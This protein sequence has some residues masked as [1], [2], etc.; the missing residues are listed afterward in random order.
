MK[1]W[2]H[3]TN[4][5]HRSKEQQ[6]VAVPNKGVGQQG[7]LVVNLDNNSGY[8]VNIVDNVIIYCSCPHSHYRDVPCKH[9]AEIMKQV[10]NLELADKFLEEKE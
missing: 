1:V 4:S 10:P 8:N 2:E 5:V 6:L 3:Y 7:F 9:M